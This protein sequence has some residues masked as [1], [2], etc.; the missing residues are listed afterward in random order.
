[1]S[2]TFIAVGFKFQNKTPRVLSGGKILLEN[3]PENPYDSRAIKIL[4]DDVFVGHVSK[5]TQTNVRAILSS[6]C[7][8]ITVN[9]IFQ[10]SAVLKID[11]LCMVKKCKEKSSNKIKFKSGIKHYCKNCYDSYRKKNPKTVIPSDTLN[12]NDEILTKEIQVTESFKNINL[13]DFQIPSNIK[14]S[15]CDDVDIYDSDSEFFVGHGSR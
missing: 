9:T 10:A 12:M 5:D 6:G 8:N 4:V 3:D 13:K 11:Q 14:V 7:Y 1:M 15:Y 2:T